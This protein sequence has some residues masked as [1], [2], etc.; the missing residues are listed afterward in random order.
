M[1]F[2]F[3]ELENLLN[4]A[5]RVETSQAQLENEYPQVAHIDNETKAVP[6]VRTEEKATNTSPVNQY[7]SATQW[8]C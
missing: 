2:Y 7:T 3:Q 6:L 1:Q 5:S 8:D 4:N